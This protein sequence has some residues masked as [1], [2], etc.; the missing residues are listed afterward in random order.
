MFRRGGRRIQAP[1]SEVHE[2]APDRRY[3]LLRIGSAEFA[4]TTCA[5]YLK[6]LGQAWAAGLSPEPLSSA[7][8]SDLSSLARPLRGV[9]VDLSELSEAERTRVRPA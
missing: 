6:A 5:G 1:P 4:Y 9:D 3:A 8:G 2:F 7:L